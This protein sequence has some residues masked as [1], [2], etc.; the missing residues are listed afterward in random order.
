MSRDQLESIIDRLERIHA[1]AMMIETYEQHDDQPGVISTACLMVEEL[2][3]EA[4]EHADG[5]LKVTLAEK[6]TPVAA[7]ANK[8]ARRKTAVR[9]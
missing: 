4:R 7:V 9:R 2:A 6:T 3:T 5:L 8:T 1:L